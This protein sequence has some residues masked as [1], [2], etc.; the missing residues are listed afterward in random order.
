MADP[1][2]VSNMPF[3]EKLSGIWNY[4]DWKFGVEMSLKDLGVWHA[5]VGYPVDDKTSEAEK[6]RNNMKAMSKITMSVQPSLY[7]EIRNAKDAAEV[8]RNLKAY[9]NQG[10]SRRCDHRSL[11]NCRLE[12]YPSMEHFTKDFMS[13][14]SDLRSAGKQ[15][16]KEFLVM[17]MLQGLPPKYKPLIMALQHSGAELTSDSVRAMCFAQ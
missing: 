13:I 8:W 12:N 7:A 15:V 11:C 2:T 9:E 5:V 4:A 10:L 14:A 17:F 1:V 16:D 3:L 6:M